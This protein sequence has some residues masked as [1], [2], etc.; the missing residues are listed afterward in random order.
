MTQ[1][2]IAAYVYGVVQGWAS[3]FH[4]RQAEAL[5]VAGHARNLDDG[6][7]Q[8]V[9]CGTQAQVD[10]LVEWLKQGG[11]AARASNACWWSHT[12]WLTTMGS[13]FVIK[14]S[15]A[16]ALRAERSDAFYRFGQPGDLGGLFGRSFREQAIQ[17][18]AAAFFFA[19]FLCHRFDQHANSR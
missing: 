16:A 10:R 13:A 12:A 2:C 1:V 9:I 3:L 18:A 5:G 4:Q 15:P 14:R 17:I 19:V 7:V 11:R 6:S 8:V